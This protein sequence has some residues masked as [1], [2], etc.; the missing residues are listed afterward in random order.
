M[1]FQQRLVFTI[2]I[3]GLM[4]ALCEFYQYSVSNYT[5]FKANA[6]LGVPSPK[7]HV[8]YLQGKPSSHPAT[9]QKGT[10]LEALQAAT[11]P[12]NKSVI[13]AMVQSGTKIMTKVSQ[14]M[15]I[16]PLKI[17]I[18]KNINHQWNHV[19]GAISFVVESFKN[20]DFQRR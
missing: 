5:K 2:V 18:S 14:K 8:D 7:T 20:I 10:F 9:L 6:K 17:N 1:L 19:S 16:S 11:Y 4:L 13:L 15:G 12:H 3:I